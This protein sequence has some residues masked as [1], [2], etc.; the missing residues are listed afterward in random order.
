MTLPSSGAISMSNV[1]VELG[2]SSTAQI[3]LNDSA[4][5]TLFGVSSGQISMSNGYGKSNRVS[6]TINIAN[7]SK[8]Y[9][10]FS[11]RG[12]T[13][14]AGKADITVNVGS[15]YTVGSTSTGTYALDTGS[16][17]TSGDT[18]TLN[19]SGYIAGMGGSAE[20]NPGGPAFQMQWPVTLNNG[21]GY[22]YSGGGGGGEGR[23]RT[24]SGGG[25]G[26]GAG[27]YHGAHGRAS[28]IDVPSDGGLTSGGRG[29]S[30]QGNYGGGAGGDGGT[31]GNPGGDGGVD[32]CNGGGGGGGGGGANGGA[33]DYPG[34]GHGL[35][36]QR[37]G[38]T[39]TGSTSRVY[40][41]VS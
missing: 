11:N 38:Y 2:L 35:A 33:G 34:G 32:D 41:G 12:G 19:N 3:T 14:V 16:G 18:I 29:A 31:L 27:T 30:T 24:Y 39:L 1:D 20:A 10:I 36:I 21:S 26:G 40:G 15:G 28:S 4:V 17:W 22:I 7:T 25:G 8:N 37:N 9:N 5:R 23:A 13:Y 6:I